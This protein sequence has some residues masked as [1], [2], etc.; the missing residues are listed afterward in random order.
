MQKETSSERPELLTLSIFSRMLAL[1]SFST[2]P[3]TLYLKSYTV[4]KYL[5]SKLLTKPRISVLS[6]VRSLPVSL[7]PE[8]SVFIYSASLPDSSRV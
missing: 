3:F 2:V 4:E 8:A 7:L 1:A 6:S 5:G